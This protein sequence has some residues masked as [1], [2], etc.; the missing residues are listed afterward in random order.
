MRVFLWK[1]LKLSYTVAVTL[2]ATMSITFSFALG[3]QILAPTGKSEVNAEQS[4]LG[5][6][7]VYFNANAP[8]LQL[9][10]RLTYRKGI[11]DTRGSPRVQAGALQLFGFY[12]LGDTDGIQ[13]ERRFG[14]TTSKT[15]PIRS[16]L[17]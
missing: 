13:G 12:Q 4:Q 7:K 11:G 9:G 8:K 15:M 10:Y 16:R 14:A 5:L 2:A 1:S 3:P 17:A 6:A